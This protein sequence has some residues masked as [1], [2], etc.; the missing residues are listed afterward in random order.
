MR[1]EARQ[2]QDYARADEIRDRLSALG[3]ALEDRPEGTT[4]RFR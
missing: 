4:W 1:A 3:V 2:V